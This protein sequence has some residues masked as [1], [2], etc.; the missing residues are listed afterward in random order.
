MMKSSPDKTVDAE[1]V[2]RLRMKRGSFLLSITTTSR[3]K[4]EASC[5]VTATTESSGG[6]AT[7]IYFEGWLD[8]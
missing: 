2:L 5:A 4:S 1:Y 3:E 7:R 8:I 6:T